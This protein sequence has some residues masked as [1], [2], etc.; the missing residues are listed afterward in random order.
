MFLPIYLGLA[1]SGCLSG[2]A[3]PAPFLL[4]LSCCGG[5]SVVLQPSPDRSEG[6]GGAGR[7]AGGRE[8]PRGREGLG[9]G[10]GRRGE[11]EARRQT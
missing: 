10:R 11:R 8:G 5:V 9:R 1:P 3:L 7:G 2:R 4:P 6:R